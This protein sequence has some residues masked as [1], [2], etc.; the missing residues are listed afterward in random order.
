MASG[1]YRYAWSGISKADVENGVPNSA[2]PITITGPAPKPQVDVEIADTIAKEDLDSVMESLGWEFIAANPSGVPQ[3]SQ[4]I[5]S[6]TVL[7]DGTVFSI[8]N[9][10]GDIIGIGVSAGVGIVDIQLLNPWPIT[11]VGVLTLIVSAGFIA[12]GAPP[13][14]NTLRVLLF[15]VAGNP[16]NLGGFN[17]VAYS[18]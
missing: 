1:T 11:G 8:I 18:T 9:Q 7:Y 16:A 14:A 5:Y 17:F 15:D 6:A 2:L 13:D 10:F 12:W 4:V 3:S